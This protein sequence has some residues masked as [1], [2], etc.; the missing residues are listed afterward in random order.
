MPSDE[1]PRLD[2]ASDSP[3]RAPRLQGRLHPLTLVMLLVNTLRGLLIPALIVLFTGS[4]RTLGI[5]LFLF[6]G[7]G[8]IPALIR[9]FTFTYRIES[10]ELITRQGILERTERHIPLARV[11]DVRFEQ[12]IM[13]RML[14][15]VDV[16]VETAGG[17]GAEASLSVLSKAD[18][19]A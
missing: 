11:Q 7:L 5:L 12:G 17:K 3:S 6:L 4:E 16:H 18:A 8:L 14:K 1:P 2:D 19:E 15:V 13:H 10:G 9:Y